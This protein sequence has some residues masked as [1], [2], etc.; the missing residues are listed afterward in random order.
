MQGYVLFYEEHW[1]QLRDYRF[2]QIYK[3]NKCLYK[4]LKS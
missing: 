1:E 3:T 4:P 2:I